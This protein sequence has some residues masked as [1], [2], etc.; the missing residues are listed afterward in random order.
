M[1]IEEAAAG[2]IFR[3]FSWLVMEIFIQSFCW[4]LGWLTLKLFTLGHYPEPSTK[5]SHV[6]AVGLVVFMFGVLTVTIYMS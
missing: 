6:I 5:N 1:P 3:F 2:G 4:G